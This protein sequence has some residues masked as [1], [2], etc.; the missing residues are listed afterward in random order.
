M[1]W[2]LAVALAA[3]DLQAQLQALT[4]QKHACDARIPA[5]DARLE[6]S[7][8]DEVSRLQ[9]ADCRYQIGRLTW[10]LDDVQALAAPDDEARVLETVLLA[11]L[12]HTREAGRV[13]RQLPGDGPARTR[14]EGVLAASR[15][16][17]D[18]AWSRVD[19][20]LTRWPQDAHSLRLAGEIA[21]LDPDGVTPLAQGAL[22]R[23]RR[24]G[25]VYNRG[26]NRLNAGDGA[27]CLAEVATAEGLAGPVEAPV[28]A[29]LAH[30][31]AALAGD[32]EAAGRWLAEAGGPGFADPDAVLR[33]AELMRRGGDD[34]AQALFEAAAVVTLAQERLRDTALV[35]I[36]A[37]AGRLDA[38][39]AVASQGQASGVS[40]ANLAVAL[41]NAGRAD[42]ALVLLETAC[43]GMTGDDAVRCWQT[44][45]RWRG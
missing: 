22:A 21:A 9:R 10:A 3:E 29:R 1:L 34:G 41:R 35:T 4:A 16:D 17:L 26:V 8:E 45:A 39:L 32:L 27:G 11:R 36:H 15:G 24:F 20:G 13:V 33:Q 14:A 2:W 18:A 12:G 38:A 43:A 25:E 44:V 6:A 28:L 31:C 37:S 7:P 19:A 30:Q 23:P 5:L 42:E 40:R